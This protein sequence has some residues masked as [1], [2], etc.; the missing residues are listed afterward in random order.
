[1]TTL[2]FAEKEKI[3]GNCTTLYRG[4]KDLVKG[5]TQ[6]VARKARQ[7]RLQHT[8]QRKRISWHQWVIASATC[9]FGPSLFHFEFCSSSLGQLVG[10][11]AWNPRSNPNS[12]NRP[13]AALSPTTPIPGPPC[14][15][16]SC[17]LRVEDTALARPSAPNRRRVCLHTRVRTKMEMTQKAGM[18]PDP[19]S[20]HT[21][22]VEG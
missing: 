3:G 8:S 22:G 20:P 18:T 16:W 15:G 19:T 6:N 14:M 11:H 9:S 1:M 5:S 21:L 4:R 7:V 13:E 2:K 12:S 10:M 17:P